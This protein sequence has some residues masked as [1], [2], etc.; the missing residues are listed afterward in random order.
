[1]LVQLEFGSYETVEP[2]K[3]NARLVSVELVNAI[4]QRQRVSLSA[5][6]SS[7]FQTLFSQTLVFSSLALFSVT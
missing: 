2:L 5:R 6:K 7:Q 4:Q 1:M 3:Q